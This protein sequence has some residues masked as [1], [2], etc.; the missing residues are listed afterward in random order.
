MRA[1]LG[2][3]DLFQLANLEIPTLKAPPHLASRP[4]AL[5]PGEDIFA[6]IRR[7]DILLQR[8]YESFLP[9]IE[10]LNSRIPL[11]SERPIS[12]TRFGP[13]IRRITIRSRMSSGMLTQPGI[14]RSG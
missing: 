3:N 1:P 12:G 2:M 10:F 13:K 14:V 5:P 7:Q 8:P 6:A 9:V 11:P 4:L